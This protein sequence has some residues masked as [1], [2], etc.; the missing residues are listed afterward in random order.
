MIQSA[1]EIRMDSNFRSIAKAISYRV[2]GSLTTAGIVFYFNH[3]LKIAAGVGSFDVIAKIGLY[4][5]H[6]R[7][8]NYLSLG[9]QRPPEYEI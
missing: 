9:R 7:V 1:N 4:Y 2:L 3:D 8:W 5:L 6:E